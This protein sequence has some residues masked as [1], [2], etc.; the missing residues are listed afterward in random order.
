MSAKTRI[1]VV[2]GDE[3]VRYVDAISSA[4]AVKHVADGRFSA[5][6]ANMKDVLAAVQNGAVVETTTKVD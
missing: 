5:E 1:Y 3:K 2:A 4:A 6:V